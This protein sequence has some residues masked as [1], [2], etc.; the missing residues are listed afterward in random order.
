VI[1]DDEVAPETVDDL[2][3]HGPAVL[4]ALVAVAVFTG[5]R[6]GSRGGPLALEAPDVRHVLLSP[7]DR[8]V[9]LRGPAYRQLRF[10][11]FVGLGVGVAVGQL[12]L[13]RLPGNGA[14]WMG[15]SALFGVVL[16]SIY[17]GSA[18]LA[19]GLRSSRSLATAVGGLPVLWAVLDVVEAVD[20]LPMAPTTPIG[21]LPMWPLEF[22]VIGVIGPIL[23]LVLVGVGFVLLPG[24]SLEAAERRTN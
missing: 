14:A 2:L 18:L 5:L 21:R 23:A 6:S 7:V 22:D 13:R 19:S 3:R 4:G 8:G 20:G 1:G 16:V 10:L 12:A 15:V 24:T 17:F 9:A 11:L